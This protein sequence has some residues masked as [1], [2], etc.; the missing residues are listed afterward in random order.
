MSPFLSKHT[1]VPLF[2]NVLKEA[3]KDTGCECLNWSHLMN[4]VMNLSIQ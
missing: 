2:I 4:I 1:T 3:L